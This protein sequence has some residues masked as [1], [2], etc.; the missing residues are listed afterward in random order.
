MRTVLLTA[1]TLAAF[2]AN[3][4]LCRLALGDDLIDPVSFTSVRLLSGALA[5]M[6]FARLVDERRASP[7]ES[8]SWGSGLALFIYAIGFSLA[9]LS[10]STGMGAL[11]LFGAV[12][13]TMI[14]AA[15]LAGERL[16]YRGWLGA[17][18]AIGGL[19]YLVLPGISA[20]DPIGAALMGLAGIAW[21]IYSIRGQAITAPIAMTRGN[22]IRTAPMALI[23]SGI[24]ASSLQWRAQGVLIA[25]LSGVIT[26]GLGYVLWYRVL[27]SLTTAQASVLQLLVP[28]LAALGGVVVL[29][30]AASLRLALSSTLVLGGIALAVVKANPTTGPID[31]DD[32]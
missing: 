15:V 4:L 11:I 20:P 3:S 23:A 5:L 31:G 25:L 30:E 27:G 22:F 10:L 26:S 28:V 7:Q 14:S 12:Q 18:L 2:A 13:V 21:G 19:V 32:P 29:S 6:V 1:F 17:L 9:Y 24:A 8:G 16:G